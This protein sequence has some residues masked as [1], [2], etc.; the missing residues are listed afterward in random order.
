MTVFFENV[1][2]HSLK[3]ESQSYAKQCVA[4]NI[5]INIIITTNN[6]WHLKYHNPTSLNPIKYTS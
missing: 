5:I 3:A 6:G 1:E 2:I 4:N